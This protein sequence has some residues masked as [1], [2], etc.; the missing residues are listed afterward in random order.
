MNYLRILEF[1][2]LGDFLIEEVRS[3]AD[4]DA[5][6][7]NDSYSQATTSTREGKPLLTPLSQPTTRHIFTKTTSFT[8]LNNP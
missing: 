5:G 4:N 3:R 6:V 1:S 2:K 8:P 7:V